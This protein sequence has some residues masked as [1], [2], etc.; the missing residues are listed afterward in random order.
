MMPPFQV[1]FKRG[2]PIV[3]TM[4]PELAHGL[5]T[6]CRLIHEETGKVPVVTSVWDQAHS[7]VSL[8]YIGCAVDVRSKHLSREEKQKVLHLAR[9]RLGEDYD[10]LLEA[11][12]EPGEHYHLELD[13]AKYDRHQ[14]VRRAWG[15]E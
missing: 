7:D 10:L 13:S 6:L 15:I 9:S 8:H 11:E 14:A 4:H 12:G 3:A 2:A 5:F 1:R